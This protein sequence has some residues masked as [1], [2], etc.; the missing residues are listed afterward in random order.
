MGHVLGRVL[1]T[2]LGQAQNVNSIAPQGSDQMMCQRQDTSKMDAGMFYTS[3]LKD[4]IIKE[5]EIRG[6]LHHLMAIP[7]GERAVLQ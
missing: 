4:K 3:L 5:E 7:T 6:F 1:G 2:K